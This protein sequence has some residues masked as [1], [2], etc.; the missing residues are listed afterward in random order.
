MRMAQVVNDIGMVFVEFAGLRRVAI[1][2]LGDGER[3]DPRSGIG[4]QRDPAFRVLR[5]DDSV[6]DTATRCCAPAPGGRDG[7]EII[8]R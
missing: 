6:E 4:K 8:L 5:G 1:A 2:L 3:D 7:I